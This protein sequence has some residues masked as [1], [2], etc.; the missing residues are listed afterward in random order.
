MDPMVQ[1]QALNQ[2]LTTMIIPTVNSTL[3]SFNGTLN[4]TLGMFGAPDISPYLDVA[5]NQTMA[6]GMLMDL[7][8][9]TAND[10]ELVDT[11]DY[12]IQANIE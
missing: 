9:Q 5:M 6:Q 1:A 2:T 8:N 11:I 3:N 10:L 7:G 4:G 12:A